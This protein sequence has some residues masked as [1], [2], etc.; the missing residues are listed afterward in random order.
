MMYLDDLLRAR[1]ELRNVQRHLRDKA[2]EIA[3]LDSPYHEK[4]VETGMLIQRCEDADTALHG[5][6]LGLYV[7]LGDQQ[8]GALL[9][10]ERD[11]EAVEPV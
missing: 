10:L 5:I 7:M 1:R 3:Q 11:S 4:L 8:A 6:L 2:W 9:T